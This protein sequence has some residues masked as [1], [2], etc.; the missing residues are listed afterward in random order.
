MTVR[1]WLFLGCTQQEEE[2]M[3]DRRNSAFN[4]I[5]FLT[6]ILYKKH[7]LNKSTNFTEN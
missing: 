4:Q 7:P 6:E 1:L 2:G 3:V 5:D